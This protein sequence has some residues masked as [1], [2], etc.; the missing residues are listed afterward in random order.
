M[1]NPQ[2]PARTAHLIYNAL[3]QARYRHMAER[4]ALER[5][6][7]AERDALDLRLREA[8]AA[9]MKVL[10]PWEAVGDGAARYAVGDPHGIIRVRIRLDIRERPVRWRRWLLVDSSN[11]LISPL[12][13]AAGVRKDTAHKRVT[14]AM[15]AQADRDLIAAGYY[16]L[17]TPEE[18]EA[19]LNY[20][21]V[22]ET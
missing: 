10:G 3:E 21:P 1:T 9:E 12:G 11:K 2:P 16:L 4:D 18:R 17:D 13:N 7:K 8:N 22:Q 20:S 19:W 14:P 15:R 5:K 6:H